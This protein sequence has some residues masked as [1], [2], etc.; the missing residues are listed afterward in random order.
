MGRMS[1]YFVRLT[2]GTRR[3]HALSWALAAVSVAACASSAALAQPTSDDPSANRP[4]GPRSAEPQRHA[5]VRATIHVDPQTTLLNATLLMADG[6]IVAVH[7]DGAGPAPDTNGYRV[8]DGA[9]LHVYP[10]LIEPWVEVDAPAPDPTTPGVHWNARVTPQRSALAGKGVDS[11]TADGLRK[12]GFVAAGIAP[13]GGNFGGS[14][15]VVSLR[16]TVD[17]RSAG[18]PAV[19][20]E[21]AFHAL[22]LDTVGFGQAQGGER[23]PSAQVGAIALV[24]QTLSD[25]QWRES[26]VRAHVQRRGS[27]AGLDASCLDALARGDGNDLPLAF[28]VTDELAAL[29]AGTIAKEFGRGAFIVGTGTELRRLDA[30][31]AM[32]MPMIVP[33]RFPEAPDVSSVAKTEAVDLR[34]LM[35][36]EQAPTNPRRLDAAGVRVSLTTGRASSR[37]RGGGG[38][39]GRGA[40][41]DNL[42]KALEQGLTE[43]RALAMLTTHPAELLGVSSVLGTIEPGKA[44]SVIVATG[45][46]FEKETK[47]RD[48]WIDGARHEVTPAEDASIDGVWA[49]TLSGRFELELHI[50]AKS[51][52][53]VEHVKGDA[54]PEQPDDP[55]VAAPEAGEKDQPRQVRQRADKV[56]RRAEQLSFVFDHKP[57]GMEGVF[58]MSAV[59]DGDRMV[60]A[61][62]K[63]DGQAFG[64]VARRTTTEVPPEPRNGQ[65]AAERAGRDGAGGGGDAPGRMGRAVKLDGRWTVM[66]GDLQM[67]MV[68]DGQSITLSVM[69]QSLDVAESRVG[70]DGQIS[71]SASGP[72]GSRY[73]SRGRFDGSNIVGRAEGPDGAGLDWVAE[74]QDP[75]AASADDAPQ[76][77]VVDAPV[78]ERPETRGRGRRD[79]ARAQRVEEPKPAS[80]PG[81]TL[82]PQEL[83]GYPFGPYAMDELP[84]A[85]TVAFVGGTVWTSGPAGVIS[86]GVV[87]VDNGAIAFVGTRPQWAEALRSGGL[88]ASFVEIDVRGKHLTPGLID[89]H[90]HTGTW[91][92]GTNE[93]GQAISAEVRMGDGT[94][95][96]A[97]NWYRQLAGGITAV[98]TLHGSANAIGGQSITQK[99][100]WGVPDPR[101]MHME[102]A[103]P[104]IKFALGENPRAVNWGDSMRWRYP[105]T[106]MGVEAIIRDRFVAARDYAAEWDRF[107]RDPRSFAS[108][109]RVD[110]ELKAIAEILAGERWVHAHSYRQDEILMLA[111]L[112]G[113]FG[114]KI[115]TFQHILEG[116]KVA[117]AIRQHA[118]GASAFSD[119]WGFKIEVQDAIP[120]A[121]AIMH[122]QGVLVSFNSDSDELAR[123][124]NTEAAKAVRHGGVDP[125]EALKFVTLNP[126]IQL[127]IDSRVG[128]L[129]KG[130]DAD[131]VVWSGD[132]L[133]TFTKAERVLIDGRE[134]FSLERDRAHRARITAERQRLIQKIL[135]S[136]PTGPSPSSSSDGPPRPGRPGPQTHDWS[137]DGFN[138]DH[139][140]AGPRRGVQ[141]YAEA[142]HW[143]EQ[144]E[145]FLDLVRRGVNPQDVTAGD[146]GCGI[147]HFYWSVYMGGGR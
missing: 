47:L 34:E 18:R 10:G 92:A 139:V 7:A 128:S 147:Q 133:S 83:G 91:S 52:T 9:G 85:Q 79:E 25:A 63:P 93:G 117:E 70:D 67:L 88:G 96:D 146:C 62:L 5:I 28:A 77:E 22:T 136:K 46:L 1:S 45:P 113:E 125:I 80:E 124:M 141:G 143:A 73:T 36:W 145:H 121:G 86:D 130:K 102:G 66:A 61:G 33:L 49:A 13:S 12:L 72:D 58:T 132:P 53:V 129:E 144:R 142:R 106:R 57:F 50:K 127:G 134:Y 11:A 51:I 6:L 56:T 87:C 90:S 99:N 111:R 59:I 112:A 94:D 3:A 60:G 126:A 48:V 65:A 75:I 123:R 54:A 101:M 31:A 76:P 8:W 43:S 19:Y 107:R 120:Q 16:R 109:P 38:G 118:V 135:A 114:F 39:G 26:V 17:D 140:G 98:N 24:R 32:G 20:R 78:P 89:C 27:R 108:P 42:R 4:N 81:A 29:R 84:A 37:G 116:Y 14:G 30:I 110:L 131:L 40:F 103:K 138:D 82:A 119:W 97:V 2:T 137:Q 21:R 74:P 105:Q 15:A 104:G 115:G 44:A 64:W 71:F 95:P 55:S 23:Y 100:R 122:E 69:G 35:L 41:M 68:I